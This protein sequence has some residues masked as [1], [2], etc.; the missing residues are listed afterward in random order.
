MLLACIGWSSL[1]RLHG[2]GYLAM[3][4]HRVVHVPRLRLERH[5]AYWPVGVQSRLQ[6]PDLCLQPHDITLHLVERVG[7]ALQSLWIK[8]VAR[9]C[10][11]ALA[12]Y[13]LLEGLSGSAVVITLHVCSW[14]YVRIRV[15][16]EVPASL[17]TRSGVIVITRISVLQTH[18]ALEQVDL[19]L[20][21]TLL[22]HALQGARLAL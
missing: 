7:R 21:R 5:T 17:W 8:V 20:G 18:R 22:C 9:R 12:L 13:L 19:V 2:V 4:R 3:A 15:R 11:S 6:A 14:A 10:C 16:L 1:I